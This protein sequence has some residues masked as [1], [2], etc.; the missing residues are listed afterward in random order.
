[1]NL[2][3]FARF[4]AREGQEDAVAALLCA[5][6]EPVRAEP[7]CIDMDAYRSTRDP[8]LFYIHSRWTDDA[9][10]EVHAQLASTDLFVKRMQALI[11][12]EFQATRTI[13]LSCPRAAMQ[14]FPAN[15][16]IRP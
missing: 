3:I 16:R 14:S 5:Q 7:C 8:R 15:Q 13:S 11:D 1:M 2:F 10:F 6:I 12:H 4:H 9:A